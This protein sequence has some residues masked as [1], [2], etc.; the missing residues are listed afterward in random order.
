MKDLGS[1]E[2]EGGIEPQERGTKG[3]KVAEGAQL[4][5][6]ELLQI[7]E[8][9]DHALEILKKEV[10]A[11]KKGGGDLPTPGSKRRERDEEGE[12]ASSL[13]RRTEELGH[14]TRHQESDYDDYND[15]AQR[16]VGRG[17]GVWQPL[18]RSILAEQPSSVIP[19]LPSY[20]GTTDPEHHLNNYFTKMQLY[21]STD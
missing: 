8:S 11:L 20:D 12:G 21:S 6:E 13:A 9:Q 1:G 4:T 5:K 15:W 17:W 2:K 7:I 3:A 14:L 18:A 16:R 10:E 19:A